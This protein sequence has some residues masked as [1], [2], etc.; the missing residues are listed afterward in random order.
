MKVFDLKVNYQENPLGIDLTNA[1]FSW[2]VKDAKGKAQDWARLVVAEDAGFQKIVY[3]SGRAALDSCAFSPD[4]AWKP[5]VKYYWTVEVTDDAGSSGISDIAAFEGGHPEGGWNGKWIRP[6]FT[7]DIAPVLCQ[8]FD[9][10]QEELDELD[11]DLRRG[12]IPEGRTE[13]DRRLDGRRLVQRKLQL[14]AQRTSA[15][16]LRR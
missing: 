5:A 12:E 11:T 10:E 6:P 16:V 15:G 8:T 13:P 1:V 7:R 4:V 2:K 9:L 14:Y 3:D